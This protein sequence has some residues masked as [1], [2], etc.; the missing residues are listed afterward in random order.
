MDTKPLKLFYSYS[1]ED[2]ELRRGL[3]KHLTT[4]VRNDVIEQWFDGE[5]TAG[6]D[7]KSEIVS[8][9][10]KSDI[11]IFLITANWL[12]S[13][14]CTEEW[15]LA[16]KISIKDTGKRLIPIIGSRCPWT[17]FDNMSKYLALPYDGKPVADWTSTDSAWLNI[18]E[19]IKNVAM[20]LKKNF[21]V[22]PEF[23][24]DLTSI[25]FC[26]K[27]TTKITL[28]DIFV[29]P[30]LATYDESERI[31]E[32]L[33]ETIDQLMKY[34][35]QIIHGEDQ[36]GKTKLAAWLYLEHNHDSRPFIYV[37]FDS[38][39]TGKNKHK[40]LQE[41]FEHQ[42]TGDFKTWFSAEN[43]YIIFDN[44]SK[45]KKCLELMLYAKEH[46]KKI[47]I[48]SSSDCFKSYYIDDER[49]IDFNVIEFKPF[50]H[51]RQESLIKNWLKADKDTDS[52]D[53]DLVDSIEDNINSIIID[54]KVLPRHPFFIL[55]ILQTYES[56][57][58]ENLKITAYGHCYH[59]LIL[60]RIIKSGISREDST[61]ESVFTFCSSLSYRMFLNGIG[62]KF[63]E[64]L[65]EEFVRDYKNEYI[66]KNS[67]LNR[68]FSD[69]GLLDRNNGEVR[70]SISYS[71]YFFLGKY[72]TENY[73]DNKECVSSM[74][75]SSYARHNSLTLIFTIHHANDVSILDEILAHTLCALDEKKVTDL[76]GGET[77]LFS[78]VLE[79][80]IPEK[81]TTESNS[82]VETERAKER[83][84]RTDVENSESPSAQ[85][86][87]DDSN[88]QNRLL[89]QIFQ[90]NKNMEI[91]SQ[92]LK[93]KTGS[94]KK[95]KLSE[96]VEIIC[97][98][99]L[100][101]A[102]VMLED[103]NE[104]DLFAE[105][106]YERYKKTDKFDPDSS[107]SS[108]LYQVKQ[109]LVCQVMLWVIGAIEKVV[110]SINKPELEEIVFEISERKATPAYHLIRYYYLLDTSR[111][112]DEKL[113]REL[114]SMVSRYK[115][116]SSFFLHRMVSLRTQHYER[117][118]I[119][120]ES[121]RQAIFSLLEVPY[122]TR[123]FDEKNKSRIGR[124]V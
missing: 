8:N 21:Q 106:I 115:R 59:A 37:D 103:Q 13:D 118:H 27:N 23:L 43:K 1:H 71:Y 46:F 48:L 107:K 102:S 114:E 31:E 54:N 85:S 7:W 116:E 97:D 91:L 55:S 90:C 3:E 52:I 40:I 87:M 47:I 35:Y 62:T 57:M 38:V 18:Y 100:R 86:A 68:M 72:L 15:E 19:G 83:K 64:D 88:G 89:N 121:Y 16:K 58:P 41:I 5:I 82:N 42:K 108:Q 78:E 49:L 44:L 28:K 33:I 124:Q 24:S 22:R 99:G 122:K 113:K 29:F 104:I 105:Y 2:D 25:E 73:Q 70:F 94:L 45:D 112:F 123:K 117:T 119:V 101:L 65:F 66:I 4:L 10:E 36:C 56:F 74:V 77:S 61:L 109:I 50:C 9:L 67:V 80:V 76:S 96:I 6:S 32:N 95:N 98:A 17:D 120:K 75:E 79:E 34:D 39:G 92:I 20:D 93:N 30:N 51:E 81:L 63:T 53:Y 60:A 11:F 84:H 12:N 69:Y 111:G 26:S 110:S 14:A